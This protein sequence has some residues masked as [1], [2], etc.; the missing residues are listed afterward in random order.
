MNLKFR[1]KHLPET[2]FVKLIEQHKAIV[3]KISNLYAQT[4]EDRKD[5]FQEIIISLWRAY[6]GFKG[7]SK[8]STW[9]YKIGLNTAITNYR[10]GMNKVKY[11]SIYEFPPEA[12]GD[13]TNNEQ[14]D[15]INIL[16]QAIEGLNKIDKAIIILYLDERSYKEISE[17]IGITAANTGMKIKRIKERLAEKIVQNKQ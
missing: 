4:T 14:K 17:I 9:I 15:N 16:Y 12:L 1:M 8:I 2:D 5:L 6:P 13:D 7:N 10:K 11:E 3:Y